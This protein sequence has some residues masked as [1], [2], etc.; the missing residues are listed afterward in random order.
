MGALKLAALALA[1]AAASPAQAGTVA[2]WRPYVE[3]ASH[4]FGVLVAW[5]ERVM[6]V[7][8]GGKTTLAGRPIVSRAGAMGLMQ[9]MPQTWAAMR[10]ACRLG[11]DPFDPHDNIIAGTAYLRL[12]YDRFGYPGMF[13]AYNAGPGRYGDYI[14]GRARL[15][16]E[17]SAYLKAVAGVVE[18]SAPLP[19]RPPVTM[20]VPLRVAGAPAEATPSIN[21]DRD[22]LFAIP[23]RR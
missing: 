10:A 1:L 16:G 5:I 3:E 23:D 22:D 4:R 2:D 20:F 7:E 15:P 18:S 8:S 19:A 9:L 14:A 17:T 6:A 12:M 21:P 11:S 13:A